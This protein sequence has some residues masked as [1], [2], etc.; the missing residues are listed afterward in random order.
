VGIAIGFVLI[1]LGSVLATRRAARPSPMP[2]LTEERAR[3]IRSPQ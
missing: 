3:P 1:V 2:S